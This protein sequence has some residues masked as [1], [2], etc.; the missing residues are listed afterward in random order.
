M[1]GSI[2]I[3]DDDPVQRRLVE[4]VVTRC[5]HGALT[6]EN[7]RLGLEC[8]QA[9]RAGEIEAVVLDLAMPEM[10]GIEVLEAMGRAG[11]TTPV[12]VQTAQ[13]TI[14]TAVSAMRLGAFDFVVKPV[15]PD[16]LKGA[17]EAAIKFGAL[18]GKARTRKSGPGAER[19]IGLDEIGASPAMQRTAALARKAAATDMPI[20][21]EGETGVGKE[22]LARAIRAA[23]PRAGKPFVTV[24]CGAIPEN[25]V[26]SILFGHEKGAFTGATEKH[27]GKFL[28]ADGGTLFL[29]E[30]G[31]LPPEAQVK[32]LRAIQEGEVDPVGA[33]HTIKVDV[34]LISATNR[35]LAKRMA[36]GLFREDLYYRLNVLAIPVP[37]LRARTSE[38]AELAGIFVDQAR[39]AAQIGVS[40]LS[41]DALKLLAAYDWPGNIRQL[42]NVIFRA[43]VLAEGD[44][45]EVSD[46]AQI[47]SEIGTIRPAEPPRADVPSHVVEVPAQVSETI[48]EMSLPLLDS[49]GEMRSLAE[50]E[51]ET[52]QA[53]I[54]HYDGRLSEV[55]R[56]LG[57]GRSTLY[58]KLKEMGIDADEGRVGRLA[59]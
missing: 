4:A 6:A 21:I 42:Q 39:S 53:A 25:L 12:I 36:E 54:D 40:G 10:T 5:G 22:V 15:G 3:I 35:D 58:R 11:I 28:E 26:E 41:K 46:F 14:D 7:G 9:A 19:R 57:I 29:D 51:R 1:T 56:R 43:A 13:G 55:A 31:E 37:P 8:L 2:L 50:L 34:R 49:R 44:R 59:S 52:I 33:R 38:I 18:A 17:V 48:D 45:L 20:L 24:N 47:A 32:L 16:R 27:L 30:V 23:G